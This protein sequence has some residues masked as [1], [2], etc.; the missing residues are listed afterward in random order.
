MTLLR[1]ALRNLIQ[2]RTRTA[3]LSTG[4]AI[5]TMM[6][7]L[8]MAM[9]AGIND[10]LVRSATTMSGGHVNVG[11]FFKRTP[12]DSAPVII[13]LD[14]LKKVVEENTPNLDYMVDRARGWGK[15][16]SSTASIQTGLSGIDAATEDHLFESLQLATES[17]YKEGGQEI[18]VGDPRRLSEPNTI[19]LFANQAKRLEV[20]VG[21]VL[22]IQTET[23]GGRTNTAD[24]TVIAVAKDVGLL[25][26]FA[27]YVPKPL[28]KELYQL[29]D[30]TSGA[31]WIYLDDISESEETMKHL[32]DVFIAK[33]YPV[34]DHEEAPFFMKFETVSGEDWTGQKLDITT[35]RD[36]VSL[37]T[38]VIT[39]F[40]SVTG[41]LIAVLVVL[42]AVG[43]MNTMW[44]TVRERTREVGTL[45]AIGMRRWRVAAMFLI[46]AL[47]LGFFATSAGAVVGVIVALGVDA[48]HITVPID[49]MKAILLSETIHFTVQI[50]SLVI[51]VGSLTL[52]TGLAAVWP[53]VRASTLKP[54]TA[55]GHAE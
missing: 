3:L 25:S 35:W 42:I 39:A 15:V 55:L 16:I 20:G 53:A 13:K 31:I 19:L 1:I 33:G 48:L 6:L 4:I 54:V 24:V 14:E 45:R 2:A 50:R 22:T 11:G 29:D 10:N 44:N 51:A 17:E 41:S 34:M 28:V 23:V 40:N 12:S 5:V 38:W 18:V 21:D 32:R 26:S 49:A 52:V 47:L 9:S 30:D 36:E 43:I 27:T 46:E 7:V 37:L 8:L